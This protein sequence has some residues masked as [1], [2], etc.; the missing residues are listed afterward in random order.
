MIYCKKCIMPNTRPGIIFD[1]N[2]VCSP[3]NWSE[4]KRGVDWES[5][6]KDLFD[7]CNWAKKLSKNKWGCVLGVSGGKDSIWQ[8]FTLRDKFKINP[9][10]VQYL[11]SDGTEL[12]R[13]NIETLQKQG[14]DLIT[15]QPNPIIAA[16][17]A[18][19]SFLN[20]G[21]IDKYSEYSLFSIPFRIAINFGIPLVF[22][23][24]NPAMEAGDTNS[25]NAPWDASGIINNNT[26]SG[27]DLSIWLDNKISKK[28]IL[29]YF[30]PSNN[31]IKKWG[32][33]AIFMGYFLNWSG[34]TNAKFAI[35]KGMNLIK[36]NYE[37]I[38]IH[39]K[40]NSLDS[41]NGAMVNSMLKH[42]KL[43]L[44]NVTE[45]SCYDIREGR[46]SRTEA[47]ALAKAFDGKCHD[48]YIMDFCK[49]IGISKKDFWIVAN[50]FRGKMWERKGSWKLKNPIWE[51]IPGISK[52]KI[53]KILDR[54]DTEKFKI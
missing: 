40:H 44:G 11:S 51:K 21:N 43:G 45:F 6:K 24:E 22:F 2:G 46:L 37:E 48:R 36:A 28:D 14:F 41:N 42:I 47:A 1:D 39:Y 26:L 33:K 49:W 8:A 32:G 27:G 34:W 7:I 12:G 5:R 4:K 31:E 18:K 29:P 25:E 13:K 10:L 3:C 16:Q 52:I 50:S 38:G 23:G 35:S 20:Y 9:L 54:I 30:F 17:L 19:K 15:F 53:K